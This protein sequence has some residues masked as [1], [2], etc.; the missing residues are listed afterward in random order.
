M[1]GIAASQHQQQR[2]KM[3]EPGATEGE[4]RKKEKGAVVQVVIVNQVIL[5]GPRQHNKQMSLL[6]GCSDSC[7]WVAAMVALLCYGT[8]G[9]PI[10]TTA[11]LGIS[12][13]PLVFQTYKTV[14]MLFVAPVLVLLLT[15]GGD[16]NKLLRLTPGWGFLSGL[17]WVLGGTCG[18]VAVRWAGMSTAIATWASV[19]IMVRAC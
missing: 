5:F 16:A 9:V 15:G 6:T 11:H 12:V 14:V 8:Y 1:M 2:S 3:C 18:V 4:K 19:M 13:N 10:K 17:L 7:G